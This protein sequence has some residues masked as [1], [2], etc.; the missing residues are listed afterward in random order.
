MT[1]TLA[2]FG[3]TPVR[4]EPYPVHDTMVD[5]AEE[6][7]VI[8]TLRSKHLSGFSARLGERFLG[9]PKVRELERRFAER[10]ATN[11]AVT[12]N[13][14]TSALHAAVSAAGIG[15]GDEVIVP[16]TT[17]SATAT[18]VVMQNAVP[19][20]A[21]LEDET[22]GLD[23]A[24]VE[25][26]ITPHTKAILAVNLFGH[27]ARLGELE[28]I[29]GRHALRLLE[30]NAQA[31]TALC[32]GRLA[33]TIGSMGILSLNYHK[34]IQTGEGGVV[35]TNSANHAEHLHMV[36]N[37]GEVVVGQ[38]DDAT[39]D[40]SNLVGWNYRLSEVQA[41]IGI[42]QVAKLDQLIAIRREL[43]TRLSAALAGVDFL[44]LPTTREGCTHAYYLYAMR[45]HADR[46][47]FSRATFAKAMRAEG[48]AVSESYVKPIY[49]EPMYQ[50]K[51]AYGSRGCPFRCPWYEGGA[52][53][54]EGL[55]PTAERLFREEFV[56]TDICKF[57]NGAREVDEFAAA[58]EKVLANVDRLRA[59]EK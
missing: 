14:A 44:T 1:S 2:L 18:A 23:P 3:G 19:V 46:A 35:L 47:G 40:I 9:G 42:P 28:E 30:D 58:M 7:A 49:L 25:A 17:M 11:H 27:P 55:C 54:G 22:F 32:D 6:R 48:I 10:F 52:R 36:R 34:A 29:A 16:P 38:R 50:R 37:H 20:F 4:T 31:P 43:A 21:D 5:E 24:A 56:L 15:P 53:Y 59:T 51:I 41:A 45:F 39:G 26:A 13:S 8:E 33:G 12:F 57:P